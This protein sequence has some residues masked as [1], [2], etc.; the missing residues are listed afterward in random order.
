MAVIRPRPQKPM[1]TAE[2]SVP[3]EQLNTGRLINWT[4]RT[5]PYGVPI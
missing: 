4:R 1:G 2:G 5:F 3:T